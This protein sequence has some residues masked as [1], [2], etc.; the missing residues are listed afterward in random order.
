MPLRFIEIGKSSIWSPTT[1]FI[2]SITELLGIFFKKNLNYLI[3]E[4]INIHRE[5]ANQL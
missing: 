4:I 3:A 5:D 1:Y 2:N